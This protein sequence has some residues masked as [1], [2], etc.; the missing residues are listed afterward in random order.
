MK[1]SP[2]DLECLREPR[3]AAALLHP[4]RLAVL[5]EARSAASATEIAGRLGLP[6]QRVNYHV[7]A[8][9]RAGL[10]LR[11]GSRKKRN[12]TEQRFVA[13]ARSFLLSPELL[14]PAAPARA[15]FV[16]RFSAETLLALGGQ[17]LGEL[18]RAR[19][20][21]RA[22]DKRLATLSLASELRFESAEQ[23]AE[24]ARA[25]ESAVLAVVARHSSAFARPDG[26]SAPGRP[27]RLLVGC[28][29]IPAA[30]PS[31]E[32]TSPRSTHL[33]PGAVEP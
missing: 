3:R 5:A 12:M 13:S 29:P 25:L 27:Y 32:S 4:L 17:L 24:F 18:A 23:R 16:D 10:L 31:P 1:P 8:L 11:A 22:A 21:A 2:V 14:G 9:H 19:A 15:E 6:R 33:P 7:R 26:S 28:W 30:A 20:E